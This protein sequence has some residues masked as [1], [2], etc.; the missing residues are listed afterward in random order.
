MIKATSQKLRCYCSHGW[1]RFLYCNFGVA[2]S[3]GI[4]LGDATNYLHT[5]SNSNPKYHWRV[6]LQS[7]TNFGDLL[8]WEWGLSQLH[9]KMFE[10]FLVTGMCCDVVEASQSDWTRSRH[11]ETWCKTFRCS[12]SPLFV[13]FQ[14]Q[15]PNSQTHDICIVTIWPESA[16]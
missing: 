10:Y 12:H 4:A 13:Q 1:K 6:A 15:I 9:Q 3:G 2:T 5:S 14:L 7:N 8:N 11:W 16:T